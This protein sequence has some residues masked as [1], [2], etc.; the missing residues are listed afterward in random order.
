MTQTQTLVTELQELA[1]KY[2][3]SAA[4]AYSIESAIE[5]R[6]CAQQLR[7]ACGYGFMAR[8]DPAAVMTAILT[9]GILLLVRY[10]GDDMD[11][12]HA[13]SQSRRDR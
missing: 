13:A 10:D 7:L 3:E 9:A 2:D 4:H 6:R 11:H 8:A 5:R 12:I 1:L